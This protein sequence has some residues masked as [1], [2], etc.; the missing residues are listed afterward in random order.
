M[1]Q[2]KLIEQRDAL[3]AASPVTYSGNVDALLEDWRSGTLTAD[4]RRGIIAAVLRKITVAHVG[5]GR[6]PIEKMTRRVTF[7]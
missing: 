1:T 5:R 2:A 6:W 4:Q 7:G 3:L